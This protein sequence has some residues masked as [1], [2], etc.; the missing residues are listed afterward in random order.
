M[1][2]GRSLPLSA[3]PLHDRPRERLV[4]VGVGALSDA[5]LV[6]IQLG[7]GSRAPSALTLA[8]RLLTDFGGV[9]GLSRADV[10]ELSRHPGVGPAK[11]CRIVAAFA[12]SD[13]R[14][15]EPGVRWFGR[16]PTSPAWPSPASVGSAVSR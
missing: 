16:R 6:A 10:H 9:D 12:L 13:G 1:D 4:S 15:P 14:A 7:S 11:A 3:P 5:E 2:A 8:A